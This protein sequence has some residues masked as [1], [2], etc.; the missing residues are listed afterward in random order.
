MSVCPTTH[1]VMPL[2]PTCRRQKGFSFWRETSAVTPLTCGPFASQGPTYLPF[3][4]L[5]RVPV[6]LL[7]VQ[8]SRPQL[9]FCHLP[10]SRPINLAGFLPHWGFLPPSSPPT[11]HPSHRHPPSPHPAA[12]RGW[13]IAGGPPASSRAKLVFSP[14]EVRWLRRGSAAPHPPHEGA[15]TMPWRHRSSSTWTTPSLSQSPSCHR[16]FEQATR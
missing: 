11:F 16:A 8:P 5:Y 2:G 15:A 10:S 7:E 6:A 4:S 13:P 3:E 12:L 9:P 1:V 14:P